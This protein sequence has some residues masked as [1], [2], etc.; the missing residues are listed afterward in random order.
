MR[1]ILNFSVALMVLAVSLLA[2][3][4]ASAVTNFNV[5]VVA[6][7]GAAENTTWSYA[8]G[9]IT[10]TSST[11]INASDIVNKLSAGPL[12]IYSGKIYVNAS[13]IHSTANTLTFKATSNII[14]GG[15]LTLQSQGGDIIFNSDS[16][17]DN[18]GHVRMGF[19][20]TCTMGNINTNGGDIVV[21]GGANPRTTSAW[22][23]NADAHSTACLAA[24]P[25]AGFALYNYSMNAGG[26]DIS[27]RAASPTISGNPSA[28]GI[29]A[30]ASGGQTNTLRTSGTGTIYVYGDGSQILNNTAWGLA[31]SSPISVITDAG[32]ITFEGRGNPSGPTN[33]RGIAIGGT[34]SFTSAS[35]NV[36]FLD[37]TNG[38]GGSN[39]YLGIYLGGAM[40]VTTAGDFLFQAD[41]IQ[42]AGALNLDVNN[43][44]L[45]ANST[46]SFSAVYSTGVINAAN[47][48]SLSIGA[49]G[50]T[51]AVTL[52][53][54][55]TTGGPIA[56][57]A[58][59]VTVSAPLTA[60]SAPITFNTTGGVTQNSTIAASALNLVG[61]ATYNP[62][63]L[64]VT[65]GSAQIANVATFNTQGGSFVNQVAFASGGRL[66]LPSGPSKAGYEFAG[67]FTS[68]SGGS[69]LP[70]FY[71]PA[72]GQDIT[73]YA[74]WGIAGSNTMIGSWM[75]VTAT[76]GETVRLSFI[77][78]YL[79]TVSAVS[80][81]NGIATIVSKSSDKIDIDVTNAKVGSGSIKLVGNS[82][83][84]TLDAIY[85][86]TAKVATAKAQS[87][88]SLKLPKTLKLGQ[89]VSFSRTA[90][91][92][93]AIKAT[94]VG[95]CKITALAKT[96]RLTAQ[97][98]S[99]NC[100][101]TLSNAGNAKFLPLN[102]V[103]A[104]K[105]TK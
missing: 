15:G 29:N 42:Q 98:A 45:T 90:S 34:S 17:A 101:V 68:A 33:G 93:L 61:S 97:G 82:Q 103:V 65:G 13:I 58:A 54:T 63:S 24:G 41:E 79:H 47:S 89:S 88:A 20:A 27:I 71:T 92:A 30:N 91:S 85:K 78:T 56:V 83:V 37:R 99:G 49:P 87:I 48:N 60:T 32:D 66:E 23:Q 6:S 12:V 1:R 25:I 72:A 52:G 4:P 39:N 64:T 105:L 5:T 22:A 46:A 76:E 75:N 73:L 96:Y 69:P 21:G 80:V 19:D 26:G 84:L 11:S 102:S 100:T 74:Q 62:Q 81:T 14:V 77:G 59:T 94:V 28:R 3:Q 70:A 10:P 53:G 7:G 8:N 86:V 50:N 2:A 16:D 18:S 51:A 55:I 43:A 38:N 67:W 95:S 40:T 36:N 35:G 44:T 104:I 9:Q 57:N 31:V